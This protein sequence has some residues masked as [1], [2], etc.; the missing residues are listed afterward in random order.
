MDILNIVSDYTNVI[1]I[2]V[3]IISVIL[4]IGL[5]VLSVKFNSLNKKYQYFMGG[6]KDKPIEALLIDYIDKVIQVEN[7]NQKIIEE[8]NRMKKNIKSCIQKAGIVRYNAFGDVGGELSYAI[9][10]LDDY[11][12]GIII[13]GI[14]SR[15][16]SYTYAKPIEKGKSIHALSAEELQALQTAQ[17]KNQRIRN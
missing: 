4:L 11:D 12:D 16:V 3:S 17:I 13:N 2:G 5:I 9:A 10:L 14:H 8:C 1:L 7:E 15:E 6:K